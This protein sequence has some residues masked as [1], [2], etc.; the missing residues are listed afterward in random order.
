MGKSNRGFTLIE[1]MVT[2]GIVSVAA[3]AFSSMM[4]NQQKEQK[5]AMAKATFNSLVN[6]L[7][8][9]ATNPKTILDSSKAQVPQ[10]VVS[11]VNQMDNYQNQNTQ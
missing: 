4:I 1:V 10:N 5:N 6:S 9:A 3:L 7:Q 8:S 11:V 2:L